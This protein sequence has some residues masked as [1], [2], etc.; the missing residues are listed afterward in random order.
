M[1]EKEHKFVIEVKPKKGWFGDRFWATVISQ[2]EFMTQQKPVEIIDQKIRFKKNQW[3]TE[4]KI[5]VGSLISLLVIGLIAFIV[6]RK[7]KK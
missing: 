3:N 6:W 7:R 2:G 4:G 5:L 1:G